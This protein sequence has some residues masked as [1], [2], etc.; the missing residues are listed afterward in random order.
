MAAAVT[1]MGLET[2]RHGQDGRLATPVSS[3]G[4]KAGA[5]PPGGTAWAKTFKPAHATG[6]NRWTQPNKP[7]TTSF[8]F[9]A[10]FQLR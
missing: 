2:E 5:R 10:S 7:S 9:L 8:P 3:L 1:R 6:P 4:A